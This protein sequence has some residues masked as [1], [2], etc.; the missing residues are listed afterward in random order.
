MSLIEIKNLTKTFPGP[1]E[2]QVLF[3]I[4]FSITKG[5]FVSI[6]GASGSGKSTLL[7]VL[8]FLSLPT[9]GQYLFQGKEFQEYNEEEVAQIRNQEMGFVFQ[10]FNLLGRS[11]VYENV[12]LPLLYSK[13]STK[14]WDERIR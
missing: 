9:G 12:Q 8:G 6:I 2:T 10:T 5:E 11:S 3:D 1:P 14:D 13:R 7:H 4:N